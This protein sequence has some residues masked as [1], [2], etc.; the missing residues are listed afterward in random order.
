MVSTQDPT[1]TSRQPQD[2]L[3]E[4]E[5]EEGKGEKMERQGEEGGREEI[6]EE[7]EQKGGEDEKGG[8]VPVEN[9]TIKVER[10]RFLFVFFS[11][12]CHFVCWAR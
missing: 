1:P 11:T 8:G 3:E 12:I 4:G 6:M 10:Q 2:G 5:K 9:G 7:G